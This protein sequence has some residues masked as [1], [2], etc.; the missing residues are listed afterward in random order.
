MSKDEF[1]LADILTFLGRPSGSVQKH[2]N[3][4]GYTQLKKA[5]KQGPQKPAIVKSLKSINVSNLTTKHL[6]GVSMQA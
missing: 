6:N 1:S 2:F 4:L 5:F 3:Y